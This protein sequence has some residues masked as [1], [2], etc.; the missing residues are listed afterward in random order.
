MSGALEGVP[1]RDAHLHLGA[2]GAELSCVN[3]A[4]CAGVAECLSRVR[5]AA[6]E[7]APG[8][9]VRCV[10]ARVEAWNERAYPSAREIDEA[11]GGRPCSIRSFD[12]HAVC[13]GGAALRAAGIDAHTPDPAG[14]V[15]ERGVGGAP[16]GLLLERAS[17]LLWSVVP[18]YEPHERREHL[19]AALRALRERGVV[20]AHDMLSEPWMARELARLADEGDADALAVRVW[21]YAPLERVEPMLEGA[22]EWTRDTVRLAG[23]KVFIDGT[24]NSR[25]AWMLEPYD[26][27]IEGKPRGVALMSPEDLDAAL[28]RCDILGMPLAMHAI[29]DA[30]VRAALDAIERIGPSTFGNRVEHCEFI[31]ERDVARFARLGVIASVQPCHLLT[32]IEALRRLTPRRE[33]R[34]FPLREL[35]DACAAEGFAPGELVWFGSDAPIVPPDPAD[36]MLAACER[37][38]AGMAPGEAVAPEQAITP[39]EAG[40]CMRSADGAEV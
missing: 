18:P 4:G 23:A 30:A 28:S 16:T 33:R 34:A 1:L 36:N 9:W 38:R 11:A 39:D 10:G 21:L 8:A 31:D 2:L 29:G 3:L 17:D 7:A 15:I 25:T 35:L 13:A 14:G 24:L 5:A 6:R 22:E 32:D 40:A 19:R 12:H 27:P 37:R 20:E 26:D